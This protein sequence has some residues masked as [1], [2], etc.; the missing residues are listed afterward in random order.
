MEMPFERIV[1][2]AYIVNDIE[3]AA[4]R[5]SE[6]FGIGPFVLLEGIEMPMRH[7]GTDGRIALS[8]ALAFTGEIQIELIQQL[9]DGPSAYRDVYAPGQEGFHHVAIL[10]R[11]FD[12]AVARHEAL[13]HAMSMSFGEPNGRTAYMD[14]RASIGSM[15]ELYSDYR[16]IQ[17]LY[18]MVAA[19]AAAWDRREVIVRP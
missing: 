5:W 8:A 19:R 1:Q 7:R 14:A 13:G 9:S 12:A 2:N 16:G 10:C 15:I 6:T 18:T 3:A 4:R 11:D 17:D